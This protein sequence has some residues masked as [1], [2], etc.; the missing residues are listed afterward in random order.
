MAIP[1]QIKM[2][3][4]EKSIQTL[5]TGIENLSKSVV[6]VN[7]DM[8][9]NFMN[10]HI[11]KI[12]DVVA[13]N[14][15]IKRKDLTASKEYAKVKASLYNS[16]ARV[17]VS[18]HF[19]MQD[20]IHKTTKGMLTETLFSSLYNGTGKNAGIIYDVQKVSD[21]AKVYVYLNPNIFTKGKYS[22]AELINNRIK[23]MKLSATIMKE[24]GDGFRKLIQNFAKRISYYD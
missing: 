4:S 18:K 5:K 16:G 24:L 20:V 22:Y 15:D 23:F 6:E 9:T 11:K 3:V 1:F 21:G 10:R 13:E 7:E 17:Y 8:A 12:R 14:Y 2:M 19:Q